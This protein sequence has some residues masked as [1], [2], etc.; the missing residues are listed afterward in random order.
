M[1]MMMTMVMMADKTRE[2]R[3]RSRWVR[4]AFQQSRNLKGLDGGAGDLQ[5]RRGATQVEALART[6]S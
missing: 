3:G 4:E 5:K 2:L 6:A 1:V